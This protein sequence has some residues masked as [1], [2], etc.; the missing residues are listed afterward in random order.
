MRHPTQ[1]YKSFLVVKTFDTLDDTFDTFD[2]TF[3]T[4]DT[5]D[6]TFD[7]SDKSREGQKIPP[8]HFCA[9]HIPPLS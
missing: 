2:E 3:D 1:K 9:T 4:F 7:T 5:L 8:C 6:D